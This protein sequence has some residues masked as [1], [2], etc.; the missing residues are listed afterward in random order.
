MRNDRFSE[1]LW[2]ADRSCPS[3]PMARSRRHL[4][5]RTTMMLR[6]IGTAATALVLI[7]TAP[8]STAR[9]QDGGQGGNPPSEMSIIPP[10]LASAAIVA[11]V[12]CKDD[13]DAAA[14]LD[15]EYDSADD[16]RKKQLQ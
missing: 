12:V 1:G 10:D 7:F 16:P 15:N 8:I 6:G 11:K 3:I 9:A 5:W 13:Y 4:Q 14:A 2:S